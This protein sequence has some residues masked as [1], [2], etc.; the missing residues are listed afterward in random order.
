[1]Q[2]SVECDDCR[3]KYDLDESYIGQR[4]KCH[5]CGNVFEVPAPQP[6]AIPEE[7]DPFPLTNFAA[8]TD[9]AGD[10]TLA[11]ASEPADPLDNADF[12]PPV[13]TPEPIPTVSRPVLRARVGWR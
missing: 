3:A 5:T 9:D 12:G 8:T 1:M 2:F 7:T 11:Q 6:I 4:V 13:D 10:A